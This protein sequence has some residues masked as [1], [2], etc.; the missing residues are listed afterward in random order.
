MIS[1]FTVIVRDERQYGGFTRA[2]PQQAIAKAKELI[3]NGA[4]DVAIRDQS[5]K[6]YRLHDFER[7]FS[8]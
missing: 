5:G 8:T 3:D 6:E 2:A 7:T 1:I 4:H